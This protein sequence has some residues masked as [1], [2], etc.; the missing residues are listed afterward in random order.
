MQTLLDG[1]PAPSVHPTSSTESGPKFAYRWTSGDADWGMTEDGQLKVFRCGSLVSGVVVGF[2]IPEMEHRKG[3]VRTL[4]PG[5]GPGVPVVVAVILAAPRT[6]VK[7]ATPKP[8]ISFY[9]PD[10]LEVQHDRTSA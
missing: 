2:K 7:G 6:E 9:R 3:R 4:L 5:Y 10:Q 1:Q 8:I